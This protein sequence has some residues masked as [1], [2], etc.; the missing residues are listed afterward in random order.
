LLLK[1][2][3][4]SFMVAA[5][6]A[7]ASFGVGFCVVMMGARGNTPA[8]VLA[9]ADQVLAQAEATAKSEHRKIVL[10]FGASWCR[11]CHMFDK[12]L[13]DPQVRAVMERSFV[14]AHLD[15][16]EVKG[17]K[18]HSNS[19]GAPE[20]M[21]KLGGGGA[22][23]PYFAMLDEDGSWIADSRIPTDDG[24]ARNAGYPSTRGEIEWFMGMV[25]KAAPEMPA[26]DVKTVREWLEQRAS[27]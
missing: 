12:F 7:L 3:G 15:V 16:G 17:D 1:D 14:T 8:P 9:P 27:R 11:P 20:E 24:P 4:D 13:E 5:R 25:K 21:A 23:Y 18:L 26:A 10:V 6:R 2:K 22:G 19:P